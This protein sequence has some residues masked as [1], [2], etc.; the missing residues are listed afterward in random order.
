MHEELVEKIRKYFKERG[1]EK[2]VLGLSGGLDSTVVCFL[3]V[4]ALGKENVLAYSLPYYEEDQDVQKIVEETGIKFT[5]INIKDHVD[6]LCDA[7]RVEDKM[8]KG[9]LMAR[10]RMTILYYFARK[11]HAL[12]AGTGNKTEW[13]LGYFTKHGDIAC[14]V[15]PIGGLYKTQVKGLA[16]E[17]GIPKAVI[18]KIPTPGFWPGQT[19]EK[20]LGMSYEKMD[21]VL[22]EGG[23]GLREKIK[24]TEHKRKRPDVL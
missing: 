15:L 20:E 9:N 16:R 5:R 10:T 7:L 4:K 1:F 21:K 14:D 24:E 2:A 3:L 19:D 6:S 11:N 13:M 23:D 22:I 8:D 17:L 18:T 12:V